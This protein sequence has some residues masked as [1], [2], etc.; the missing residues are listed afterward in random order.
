MPE[1][2][3]TISHFTLVE[4]IGGGGMGVVYKA[5]D[6]KLGRHVA[7]KFL[8]EELSRDHKAIERFKR[9]ARSAS[10]LNHANICTIYEIDEHKGQYFIAIEYL[11]GQ[12][13]KQR[14]VG[15]PLQMDEILD[16]AI[17]VADGLDSAHT[18]GIIHRDLKP[19]NIFITK[20]GTAKILDFGLAKLLPERS[21][22]SDIRTD[23]TTEQ[24][25]T[26]PGTI[27]GTV[28]YMSP[29][30]ALGKELSVSTDLFSFGIVLYEMVTGVLPFRGTTLAATF[31]S[32]LHKTPTAPVRLNPEIPDGM[33]H[34][35]TKA[36]DKD[37]SLRYQS[38]SEL[39]TDLQRVKRDLDSGGKGISTSS[40]IDKIPKDESYENGG[41]LRRPEGAPRDGKAGEQTTVS[42]YTARRRFRRLR[43]PL[44]A[45]SGIILVAALVA[46]FLIG[47]SYYKEKQRK[48]ALSIFYDWR[49]L[50]VQLVQQ[51]ETMVPDEL[52]R[53]IAEREKAERDY[54]RFLEVLDVYKGKTPGQ[55]A[56]MRLARRLGETDFEM[57]SDFHQTVLT[58]VEKWKST[59]RLKDALDRAQKQNLIQIILSALDMYGLPR[60]FFFIP[61]QES[62][63][64]H[65]SVGPQ[66]MFGIA[67]GLWQ[68]IPSMAEEYSLKLGPLK[69]E[70]KYD[71]LDERHDTMR[72][73][74]AAVHHL[75]DLYST[76]AA[77][78]G[79]L[80]IA[81]YNYGQERIN[82]Q[83]DRLPN[84]PR[85]RNFWNF[86]RNGWLPQETREYVMW[87]FSAA[88]IGQNPDLFQIDIA[89]IF[90]DW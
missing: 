20:R 30:Q 38:A 9:E 84:D 31:D 90:R 28:A 42:P 86:Y 75:A 63:Y 66:T 88:L 21:Q 85:Q 40:G 22:E 37:S 54:E 50:G 78:S 39:R 14:I 81:A 83:L 35:I 52:A 62:N 72:S 69:D 7:L 59:S 34:I 6:T 58:Y 65:K 17:Q 19:A 18:E 29:E 56:I 64:N 79:L 61:L 70:T 68:I 48:D 10:A 5:E 16:V 71:P 53:K 36:L 57:P 87:I 67:K 41:R 13:L 76:K 24:L 8:Q 25:V 32:I 51:R 12:T 45:A 77:A 1:I 89:P 43:W 2:G 80:V 27:M 73:T 26:K 23:A 15:K 11:E 60:E 44:L 55:R 33:D 74:N 46:G 47:F 3:Q 4:K 82:Q 49:T